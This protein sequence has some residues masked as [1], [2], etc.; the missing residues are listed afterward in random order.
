[1]AYFSMESKYIEFS[2]LCWHPNTNSICSG[3]HNPHFGGCPWGLSGKE[4]GMYHFSI[5]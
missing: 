3:S 2:V 1:M 4:E 5:Y